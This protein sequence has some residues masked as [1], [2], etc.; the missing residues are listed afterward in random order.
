MIKLKYER[1]DNA[2]TMEHG[3]V[4][5]LLSLIDAMKIIRNIFINR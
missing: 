4:N 2:T 3:F 5:V 1:I